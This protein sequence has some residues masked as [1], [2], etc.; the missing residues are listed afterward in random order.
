MK[1]HNVFETA[2]N[3][4]ETFNEQEL[5]DA[6]LMAINGGAGS[7]TIFTGVVTTVVGLGTTV[8]GLGT[9]VVGVGEVV[10]GVLQPRQQ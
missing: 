1:V 10:V 2:T 9:T 7:D 4:I 6:D 8:I 5:T 3:T